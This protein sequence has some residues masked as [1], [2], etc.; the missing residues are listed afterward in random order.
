MKTH[1]RKFK[2]RNSAGEMYKCKT[3]Q[4][5]VCNSEGVFFLITGL[6]DFYT[7]IQKLSDVV[8]NYKVE[9]KG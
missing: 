2:I 4:M 9:W 7:N 8:G 1:R 6:D 5:L 3:G